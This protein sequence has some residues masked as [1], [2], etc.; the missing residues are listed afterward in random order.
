LA[1]SRSENRRKLIHM[2]DVK[3]AVTNATLAFAELMGN[4]I[5]DIWLE[6]VEPSPDKRDWHITL[7]ALAPLRK[8]SMSETTSALAQ[9]ISGTS[10]VERI[11]KVFTIDKLT[12]EV[13][14][15]NIRKPV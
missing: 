2:T 15:M 7:S 10:P 4:K 3:Q 11:Y 1:F 5:S 8:S 9:I 14:A 6:E 12:N 13:K